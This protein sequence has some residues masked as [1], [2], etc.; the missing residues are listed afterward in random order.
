MSDPS[1]ERPKRDK[2]LSKRKLENL[3]QA[4]VIEERKKKRNNKPKT[5]TRHRKT[6]TFKTSS[7]KSKRNKKQ[8]NLQKREQAKAAAQKAALV[9][10]QK[11]EDQHK[12]LRRKQDATSFSN[13]QFS[14]L[15]TKHFVVINLEKSPQRLMKFNNQIKQLQDKKQ[16]PSDLVVHVIAACTAEEVATNCKNIKDMLGKSHHER[17]CAVGCSLSH[18]KA[19]AFV[20]NMS[21]VDVAKGVVVFEDNA[22]LTN[23]N[24]TFAVPLGYVVSLGQH[25]KVCHLSTYRNISN[26][27]YKRRCQSGG[28]AASAKAYLLTS[29][30]MAKQLAN[31]FYTK[32][33]SSFADSILLRDPNTVVCHPPIVQRDNSVST[34]TKKKGRR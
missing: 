18:A 3:E 22:V 32:A 13:T 1:N 30:R 21:P 27:I 20:H 34:I 28:Y 11:K 2:S 24:I 31:H 12:A 33:H 6:T 15:R 7:T 9:H 26:F 23:L 14:W 10:Q 5:K 29:K 8:S 17:L 16:L 19:C 4:A 25:N